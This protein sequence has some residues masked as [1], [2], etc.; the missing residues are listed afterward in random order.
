M[1]SQGSRYSESH[2][3]GITSESQWVQGVAALRGRLPDD[4][5]FGRTFLPFPVD[6]S[7]GVVSEPN[8]F[9]P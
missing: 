3:D 2:W 6:S 5:W 4:G 1:G 7:S 9:Q 8:I